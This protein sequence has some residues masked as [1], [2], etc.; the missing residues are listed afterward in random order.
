[1]FCTHTHT[2][3]HK[4]W[5]KHLFLWKMTKKICMNIECK[6]KK[7]DEMAKLK[8]ER[9]KR[10]HS[11][12]ERERMEWKPLWCIII[13]I[14]IIFIWSDVGT[15]YAYYYGFDGNSCT[16]S[17]TRDWQAITRKMARKMKQNQRKWATTTAK[18][19][20]ASPFYVSIDT[21]STYHSLT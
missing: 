1:M 11:E 21:Y 4:Y 12:R 8:K 3:A 10:R 20:Q 2:K 14:I 17:Y 15:L 6:R 13:K 9:K 16:V 18:K 19:W 7:C 5:E